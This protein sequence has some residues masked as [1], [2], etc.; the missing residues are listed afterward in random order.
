[1]AALAVALCLAGPA[2]RADGGSG[3]GGGSLSAA[4][5]ALAQAEAQAQQ[6]R[7]RQ[8][9]ASAQLDAALA[10]L[11]QAQ[12]QLTALQSRIASLTAE[13]SSDQAEV[14][15][16][17]TEIQ[18]DK[19]ELAAFIR[20]SYEGGGHETTIEYLIDATSI[21]DL[22]AR[23]G[24]VEHVANA[25]NVLVSQISAEERQERLALA[26]TVE[27][28]TDAQ[29][30]E[31]QA[32]TE[33]VIVAND[34]AT[35]AE[36]LSLDKAAT[37]QAEGAV[38]SAQAQYDLTSEY[39]T[40][41]ADAAAAL[42]QARADDT[43][44]SPIAGAEFTEDTDL[45]LPSG[46]NAQTIN[47]FLAGTGLAGLGSAYMQAEQDFGVSARYLVAHSIE[48]SGWGTSA[49]AREKNNLFGWDAYDAD[50]GDDA[51]SFSS[52][53]ACILYVAQQVREKYL[54]AGGAYYHGPT[55][56][57]MN[58]DYASDPFWASK[59]AAIAQSIPLP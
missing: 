5:Q 55:L 31:Q 43:I 37:A 13:V 26:A 59:I 48:E 35:D 54:S 51:M 34:E 12:T 47:D 16:L 22:V 10:E 18:Q 15:Q 38:T 46:E 3:S 4:Q 29:A 14:A 42:A 7:D 17:G 2:V 57:G 40:S 6:A 23:V 33:E 24:E 19:Q 39:G 8:A 58:V 49:I 9:G 28:R 50:P 32:A 36:Q 45:T 56:R 1:V 21:S 30:A 44:F 20:A 25:G 52:F 11:A 41:Y 53:A 27:A